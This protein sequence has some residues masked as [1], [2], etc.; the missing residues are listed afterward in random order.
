[1]NFWS[2]LIKRLNLGCAGSNL[3]S[4]IY[5]LLSSNSTLPKG[6]QILVL[7]GPQK[8]DDF[9]WWRVRIVES[10]IE[11]WINETPGW[12]AGKW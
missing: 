5:N 1:M 3:I 9:L 6:A 11:G 12:F 4:Y 7:E 2:P 10:G 8:K